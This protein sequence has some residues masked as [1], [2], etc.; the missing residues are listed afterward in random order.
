MLSILAKIKGITSYITVRP[1]IWRWAN[2]FDWKGRGRPK[3]FVCQEQP[4]EGKEFPSSGQLC[5][6]RLWPRPASGIYDDP[7]PHISHL[8]QCFFAW[9]GQTQ[10]GILLRYQLF[11]IL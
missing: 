8:L 10:P 7:H 2:K 6:M 4:D 9:F 11:E 1:K 5:R 3:I